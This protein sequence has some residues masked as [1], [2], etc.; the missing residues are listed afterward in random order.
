MGL[1]LGIRAPPLEVLE[2]RSHR[3]SGIWNQLCPGGENQQSPEIPASSGALFL[4]VLVPLLSIHL[5]SRVWCF[6]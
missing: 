5:V 3:L 4:V 2:A 1:A 6:L